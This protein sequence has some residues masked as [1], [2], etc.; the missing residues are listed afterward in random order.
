M[1]MDKQEIINAL[2]LQ[3]HEIR[4]AYIASDHSDSEY[5]QGKKDGYRQAIV[6]M[7]NLTGLKPLDID[8]AFS[9]ESSPTY[10]IEL[11]SESES[12]I[13]SLTTDPKLS[14]SRE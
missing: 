9:Q 1:D 7:Q 12:D 11:V 6:L 13:A 3:W 14:L 10:R 8:I 2:Y 4:K 5:M